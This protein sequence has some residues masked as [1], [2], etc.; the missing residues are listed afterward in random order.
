[1]KRLGKAVGSFIFEAYESFAEE[2]M[3]REKARTAMWQKRR[4]IDVEDGESI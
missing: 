4:R 1:M 2:E 3:F